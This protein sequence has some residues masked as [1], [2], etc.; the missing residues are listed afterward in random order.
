METFLFSTP[1]KKVKQENKQDIP[2]PKLPEDVIISDDCNIQTGIQNYSLDSI[3]FNLNSFLQTQNSNQIQKILKYIMDS[4]NEDNFIDFFNSQLFENINKTYFQLNEDTTIKDFIQRNLKLLARCTEYPTYSLFERTISASTF[5]ESKKILQFINYAKNIANWLHKSEKNGYELYI[6]M[7]LNFVGC[8]DLN[9]IPLVI[10]SEIARCFVSIALVLSSLDIPYSSRSLAYISSHLL[11]ILK[12]CPNAFNNPSIIHCL[13]L[14]EENK[15]PTPSIMKLRQLNSPQAILPTLLLIKASLNVMNIKGIETVLDANSFL[16]SSGYG[17]I[18]EKLNNQKNRSQILEYVKKTADIDEINENISFEAIPEDINELAIFLCQRKRNHALFQNAVS[19]NLGKILNI[20]FTSVK[21]LTLPTADLKT[22]VSSANIMRALSS[23]E[24]PSFL[25]DSN[26]ISIH[27]VHIIIMIFNAAL[28]SPLYPHKESAFLLQPCVELYQTI[29]NLGGCLSKEMFIVFDYI[30]SVSTSPG[31]VQALD[32]IICN[33]KN[34]QKDTKFIITRAILIAKTILN[35]LVIPSHIGSAIAA[36]CYS[37]FI[38]YL[39]INNAPMKTIYDIMFTPQDI[40]CQM[41]DMCSSE[42]SSKVRESFCHTMF[43]LE[44]LLEN[45]YY[46]SYLVMRGTG[47]F[48]NSIMFWLNS[49]MTITSKIKISIIKILTKMTDYDNTVAYEY[50]GAQ[51]LV[52]DVL[53]FNFLGGILNSILKIDF[54]N[55]NDVEKVTIIESIIQFLLS[56]CDPLRVCQFTASII[57]EEFMNKI[58]DVI[59]KSPEEIKSKLTE[60]YEIVIDTFKKSS[61]VEKVVPSIQDVQLIFNTPDSALVIS[62]IYQ[63]LIKNT[64]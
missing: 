1:K 20:V 46:K 13:S 15:Y 58:F 43:F 34:D 63:K 18:S 21:S 51:R 39:V 57:D 25:G 50:N 44:K 9:T 16:Q 23:L 35:L 27:F 8:V 10:L 5:Q 54:L 36:T 62:K 45:P 14:L 30:F 55:Y 2:A 26:S 41:S 24:I 48:W 49:P 59:S 38:K 56:L 19:L 52:T 47:R 53:H 6:L 29:L 60:I 32:F 3:F 28:S 42:K 33:A 40:Y 31:A 64:N 7:K 12:Y 22:L 17:I 11:R 37:D 4:I 61:S